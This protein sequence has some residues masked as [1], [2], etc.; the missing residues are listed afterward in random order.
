LLESVA[1]IDPEKLLVEAEKL[2]VEAEKLL[3]AE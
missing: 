2:L 1:V 3:E